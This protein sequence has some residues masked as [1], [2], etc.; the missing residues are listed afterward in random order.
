MYFKPFTGQNYNQA[1]NPPFTDF[2]LKAKIIEGDNIFEDE[3]DIISNNSNFSIP[4]SSGTKPLGWSFESDSA[5]SS[6]F[7]NEYNAATSEIVINHPGDNKG[8]IK[9][10][11]TWVAGAT[12]VIEV[13]VSEYTNGSFTFQ[14]VVPR[15]TFGE[16]GNPYYFRQSESVSEAGTYSYQFVCSPDE[17]T[18]T[19]GWGNYENHVMINFYSSEFGVS[20]TGKISSIT[21]TRLDTTDAKVNCEIL[22]IDGVPPTVP[23]TLSQIKFGVDKFVD[24]EKIFKYKFPRIAYRYKYQD[25]EYSAISP[26][27]E[28]AFLPGSF[29]FHPKKGYNLGM[30]NRITEIEVKNFMQNIPDGVVE[31]DILYKEDSSSNV[32]VV[33]TIKPNNDSTHWDEDTYSIESEQINRIIDS[34][35]LLRPWDNVPRKALAQEVS[36]SRII[37]GNYIQSYNMLTE[38]GESYYPDFNFDILSYEN[39]E[40]LDFNKS[41]SDLAISKQ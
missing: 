41:A 34:N 7:P 35:Q 18:P 23:S 3:I 15:S 26:F 9:Q 36:G 22:S 31:V 40:F 21:V 37:Y 2:V 24:S 39:L 8:K 11:I 17:N 28:V 16:T 19:Q 14:A 6:T 13:N 29:D 30:V 25:N 4:N 20:F 32:Y 27:S 5:S 12:Y 38:N 10:N 1:P 33:D